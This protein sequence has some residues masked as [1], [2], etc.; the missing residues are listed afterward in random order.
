VDARIELKELRELFL[1]D[2][3]RSEI[4]SNCSALGVDWH[5]SSMLSVTAQNVKS[6]FF[7]FT[8]AKTSRKYKNSKIES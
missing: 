5:F 8:H 7:S 1:R 4:V 2:P 3:Q 6:H